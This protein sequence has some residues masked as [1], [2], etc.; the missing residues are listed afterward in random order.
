M[1]YGRHKVPASGHGRYKSC[2]RIVSEESLWDGWEAYAGA[3]DV[4]RSGGE[5]HARVDSL[6]PDMNYDQNGRCGRQPL[7]NISC[8]SPICN[9]ARELTYLL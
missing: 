9:S 8:K 7:T 6:H 1:K 4:E 2:D 3:V 5:V